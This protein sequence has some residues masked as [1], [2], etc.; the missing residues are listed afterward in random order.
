MRLLA[1]VTAIALAAMAT[2]ATPAAAEHVQ[3]DVQWACGFGGGGLSGHPD[4]CGI[5][6]VGGE[7]VGS[8]GDPEWGPAWI[9]GDERVLGVVINDD[10]RAVPVKMLDRHEILNDIIG[11][12]P[13]AVTYCPL[14]GSGI[15]FERTLSID[16]QTHVLDF[17][18]SGF[19]YK[20]DL[21]MWDPQTN[22]LWT[23]ILGEPIGTL[24]DERAETDHIEA[25]LEYVPT[26]VTTWDDW[27]TRHPASPMLQAVPGVGYGGAYQGYDESCQFGISGH[28][29]CDIAGLH[30]K[31]EV[32]GVAGPR[33]PM[34]FP[35]TAITTV[36]DP[37]SGIVV[38]AGSPPVAFDAASHTFTE[39]DGQWLDEQ[40]RPWDLRT[41]RL[42]DGDEGL[43]PLD[44]RTMFWFAWHEHHPDTG[45]W[46][47]AAGLPDGPGADRSTP[48]IGLAA[49][50]AALAI[51]A[52]RR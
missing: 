4:G 9:Q 16:G 46:E 38:H 43:E 31:V 17:T 5:D 41:G 52:R 8:D 44:A 51:A 29:D 26:A 3:S 32:V 13:V 6:P 23:Q 34:A 21:V 42:L 35:A 33:G 39:Q 27:N 15:T 30:P 18:A 19:L 48:G 36:Y 11:G 10:A 2:M 37:T 45:L 14:C 20:H 12:V 40:G 28:N 7:G 50:V 47:P 24:R 1:S 25:T 49:V 22:T